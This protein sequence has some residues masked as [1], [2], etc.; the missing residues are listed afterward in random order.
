MKTH[1]NNIALRFIRRYFSKKVLV[2]LSFTKIKILKTIKNLGKLAF[3]EA[4]LHRK[5][6]A[7]SRF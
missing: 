3:Q 6:Y 2:K 1:R 7:L 4:R 5:M